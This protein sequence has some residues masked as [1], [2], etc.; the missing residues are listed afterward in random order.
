MRPIAAIDLPGVVPGTPPTSKPEVTWIDPC[1]LLVDEAYQRGLSEKGLRLIRRIVENFDWRKFKPPTAVY[2]DDGLAVLDGQHSAIAAACHPAID[3]IPVVIVEAEHLADRAGA[4]V[5][6]NRDRL[7]VTG[8]ALHKAA[9]VAGDAEAEAIERVC[10]ACGVTVL[11]SPPSNGAYRPRDTVAIAALAGL[12]RRVG[13]ALAVEVLKVLADAD[14]APITQQ[15]LRAAEALMISDEHVGTFAPAELS[16]AIVTLGPTAEREA[17]V[18]AATHC[19]PIWKGLVATWL[20]ATKKRKALG[21]HTPAREEIADPEHQPVEKI[22]AGAS[23]A[24]ERK[25]P[26]SAPVTRYLGGKARFS[27]TVVPMIGNSVDLGDPRPGRSELDR[28][29]AEGRK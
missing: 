29:M 13:E 11:R 8:M 24:V 20:A 15:G 14:M 17:K 18:F 16:K 22:S 3:T 23:K 2:T 10:S 28:R 5:A 27:G 25:S 7:N 19:V 4:F 9:V 1:D 12:I 6:I 21:K 26:D